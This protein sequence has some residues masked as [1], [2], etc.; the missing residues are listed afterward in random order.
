MRKHRLRIY[1]KDPDGVEPLPDTH[2]PQ[3]Q[4]TDSKTGSVIIINNKNEDKIN[5][6]E[7]EDS[8]N[9]ENEPRDY[10]IP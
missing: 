5:S 10:L 3:N 4:D 6:G 8:S 9:C 7:L 1:R 2:P